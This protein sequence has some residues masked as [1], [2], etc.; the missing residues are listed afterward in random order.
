MA[1]GSVVDDVQ[2]RVG[3]VLVVGGAPSGGARPRVWSSVDDGATF[4]AEGIPGV[5][6]TPA[7]LAAWG[8]KWLTVG[9]GEAPCPHPTALDTWVRDAGGTWAEAP[10]D[11]MMCVGSAANL[12]TVTGTAVLSGSGTGDSP[13]V[14]SSSDG[15]HW[16]DHSARFAG[17]LPGPVVADATEFTLFGTGAAGPW[18]STSRDGVTWAPPGRLT[19]LGA[20]ASVMDAVV[21]DGRAAAI[22]SDTRGGVGIVTRDTAGA[23]HT[24][25]ARGLSAATLARV[26]SVEGGLVALGGDTK[27]PAMWVSKEGL[28]WRPI[29]VPA[30]ATAAGVTSTLTGVATAEGRA[31]LGGRLESATGSGLGV[32]WSGPAALLAP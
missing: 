3:L 16:A 17:L 19:D 11:Q 12:A 29:D 21:V 14:W 4:S 26:E 8:A 28:S 15:L 31:Y 10:F 20:G 24:T 1:D 6:R 7:R 5:T 27:G 30:E 9:G 22:V 23:W 32:L 13:I 18:V 2:A 25:V